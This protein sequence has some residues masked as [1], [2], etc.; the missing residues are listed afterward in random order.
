ML[1]ATYFTQN[2]RVMAAV[3]AAGTC[4]DREYSDLID[5]EG[6]Q[7]VDLV[8][9]GGG[10][11]GIAL[12]G[13]THVLEKAGIRF[14]GIGGTSA[15]AINAVMLAALGRPV[16]EKS[17]QLAH[18][19]ANMPI[20]SFIDGDAD[21]RD[22]SSAVLNKA[23][24]TKL[25]WKAIQVMDNLKEDLGLH[26]GD[27]FLKWLTAALAGAGVRT[28]KELEARLADVPA[29]LRMRSGIGSGDALSPGEKAGRLAMVAADVTTETKVE[30]PR[31]A[32]LYWQDPGAVNPA[33]YAR[34]SM[35]I[36]FFFHP[37]RV[38]GCPKNT[39]AQWASAGYCGVLPHEVIFMDGG[40][41][42]NFPINLFHEP[43]RVPLAPTFGVKIGINR[44]APT[45]ITKPAELLS[46]IFDAAR[47]TLDEDFIAQNP[48]YQQLVAMIDTGDHN[49][50]N[51]SMEDEEKQ[52]LFARGAEAAAA[53]LCRFDWH[54][55]K[56]TREGI[57]AAFKA[58]GQG[59]SQAGPVTASPES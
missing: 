8:M 58:S 39:A 57:A 54:E 7:Y 9:E 59:K 13:Y 22:F 43:Y 2:E 40:I 32:H 42:S 28:T 11:L 48:D 26:P 5:D 1:D 29:S 3:A 35:S 34:A 25:L 10:V 53:F 44:N 23:R 56:K 51:F 52:D 27:A 38:S 19:L 15:G 46:A 6:H 20:A 31:M 21:A 17:D 37:Y 14:L 30:F 55:Y 41:M 12:V 49:W 47:H 45:R 50:L 33:S 18:L 36:P 16:D 4:A 24:M